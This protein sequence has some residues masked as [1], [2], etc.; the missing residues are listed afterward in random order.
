MSRR[1]ISISSV[2]LA[3]ALVGATF[4]LVSVGRSAG[5][6]TAATSLPTVGMTSRT[7]AQAEGN[8]GTAPITLGVTLS[9]PS[10]NTVT[11]HYATA[12]GTATIADDDYVATS[13]DLTFAPGAT[14]ASIAVPIVGDTK[15][16]DY[17]TF[18]VKLSAPT[19][20]TLGSAVTTVTILN[21]DTPQLTMP[22]LPHVTAGQPAVF[23]PHLVQRYFQPITLHVSTVDGTAVAGTDY[24]AV[25][26]NVTFPAGSKT[27]VATSVPT[28]AEALPDGPEKFS[29][30]ISG[31]GI[32]ATVTRTATID[33]TCTGA[34]PPATYQ[35][36]VVVVM[37]NKLYNN[38]IG[39]ASA[40]FQTALARACGSANHYATASS[41]SRPN[42]IGMTSGDTYG[43][44]GSDADPPGACAP[45]SP[46]L[47][48]QVIA[49]GG[50]AL[51]YAESMTTN[52]Q[53][54]S[55]GE[56]AAK[57]NPWAYYQGESALCAQYDEPMPATIDPTNLPT[58]LYL[59]PNLCDD[60][61]DCAVAT[62]DQ[63]L[64]AHLMPILQSAAFASG[65]TAVIVTYDEYTNLPNMFAARSVR[66]GTVVTA[67]TSHYGLLRTIEDMLGLSPLGQA[68]SAASLRMPLHL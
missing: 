6:S 21:D 26:E 30:E 20:A 52:C 37:E 65:S 13:G 55:S 57:H 68:A 50:T 23:L 22:N 62:G 59:V 17:E 38:V 36:V 53:Q 4:A 15:L 44:D 14:T 32:V 39:S 49:N 63:W 18:S 60:A 42:Y 34:A 10:T 43:C 40:P 12:D 24:G 9:Q 31:T 7:A 61:H 51:T 41:P 54:V 67:N 27:A 8:S 47:F 19:N 33:G 5:S 29:L 58:L 35:H 46:S 11:V 64:Q 1:A 56:Y 48:G 3:C 28:N 45:P 16:E 2:V 66:P 25:S